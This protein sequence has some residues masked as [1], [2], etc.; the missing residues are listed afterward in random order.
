MPCAIDLD[1]LL[2]EKLVLKQNPQR[3]QDDEHGNSLITDI[4]TS[5]EKWLRSYSAPFK[6]KY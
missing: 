2:K 1:Y 6:M 4:A 5:E 3:V